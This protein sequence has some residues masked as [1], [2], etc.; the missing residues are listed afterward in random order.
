M[1][2][3]NTFSVKER[4]TRQTSALRSDQPFFL[5]IQSIESCYKSLKQL[6][7]NG[8]VANQTTGMSST[9]TTTTTAATPPQWQSM[10]ASS[11]EPEDR[12]ASLEQRLA[13]P[14]EHRLEGTKSSMDSFVSAQEGNGPDGTNFGD[15]RLHDDAPT[16]PVPVVQEDISKGPALSTAPLHGEENPTNDVP[17]SPKPAAPESVNENPAPSPMSLSSGEDEPQNDVPGV[18]EPAVRGTTNG[19]TAPSASSLSACATL[20]EASDRDKLQRL[21]N[22]IALRGDEMQSLERRLERE[23][24]N[25]QRLENAVDLERGHLRRLESEITSERE[26]SQS[27]ESESTLERDKL[28]QSESSTREIA[29]DRGKL[30]GEL[31][32]SHRQLEAARRN[33]ATLERQAHDLRSKMC[34]GDKGLKRQ[35]ADLT[36]RVRNHESGYAQ[37]YRNGLLEGMLS[38]PFAYEKGVIDERVVLLQ[39]VEAYKAEAA[40]WRMD[41]FRQGSE[42]VSRCWQASVDEAVRREREKDAFVMEVLRDELAVLKSK[43][44]G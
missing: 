29:L 18:S 24:I 39:Q 21:Y 2:R 33:I 16:D 37:T 44:E 15:E 27:L 25:V 36:A 8:T 35:V 26:K 38:L 14:D 5:L 4:S 23:R 17:V 43:Q 20:R 30:R 19:S 3:L 22:E 42:T 41:A 11:T 6:A 31:D 12:T 13:K 1:K 7:T 32:V 28:R 10:V 9:T 34:E 40:K